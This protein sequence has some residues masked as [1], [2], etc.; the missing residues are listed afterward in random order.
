MGIF[1]WI[2]RNVKKAPLRKYP[3]I[4][5]FP[6]F[7]EI[8]NESPSLLVLKVDRNTFHCLFSC[9]WS[10]KTNSGRYSYQQLF[11]EFRKFTRK[12]YT[13]TIYLVVG[14]LWFY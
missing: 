9:G 12:I 7:L 1:L 8:I 4:Q 10:H 14:G 3:E 2:L 13:L 6:A 11:L 5:S